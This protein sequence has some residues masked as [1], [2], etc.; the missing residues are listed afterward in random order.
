MT[1]KRKK[2]REQEDWPN[3]EF[4][5]PSG[6]QIKVFTEDRFSLPIRQSKTCTQILRFVGP[7]NGVPIERSGYARVDDLLRVQEII[8]L[9]IDRDVLVEIVKNNDK[10]R[11]E[12]TTDMVVSNIFRP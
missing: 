4:K 10:G 9:E 11:F 6:K 8:N 7:W 2:D 3:Y 12:M 1:K 5:L